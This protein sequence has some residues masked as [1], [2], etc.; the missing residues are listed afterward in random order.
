MRLTEFE[1]LEQEALN[2]AVLHKFLTHYRRGDCTKEQALI[3]AC[4]WLS[5]EHRR[6]LALEAERL[7]K[8]KPHRFE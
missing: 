2:D 4:I 5:R 7:S 6:L 8:I 3:G 1:E